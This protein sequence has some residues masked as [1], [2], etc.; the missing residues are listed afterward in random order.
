MVQGQAFGRTVAVTSM[1]ALALCGLLPVASASS[2]QPGESDGMRLTYDQPRVSAAGGRQ[3]P[4]ARAQRLEDRYI[5]TF[6]AGTDRKRVHAARKTAERAG[7]AAYYTYSEAVR[8][9]AAELT[10]SALAALR[11]DPD[12]ARIEPDYSISVASVQ[13]NPTNWGLDRIDQH[14]LPL[15]NSYSFEQTGTGITAY[16]I[17]TGVRSTHAELIGRVGKGTGFVDDGNGSEDCNGH[18][19]HVAAVLAGTNFGVAKKANVVSVRVLDCDG[20]GTI[21]GVVAGVDWVTKNHKGPSIANMSLGGVTSDTLDKAVKSSIASGVHYI[22]AAGNEGESACTFSPA[23]LPEAITVG[24]TGRTDQRAD[25]SNF[26]SC[27]DL[28]APGE[29]ILSADGTTDAGTTVLSGTSMA[30]PHV[31]GVAA[32]WLEL[33]P[34]ATADELR[35]AVVQIATPDVLGSIG[36]GSPNLLLFSALTKAPT[37]IGIGPAMALPRIVIGT[38]N[39]SAEGVVPVA[40]HLDQAAS[41]GPMPVRHELERSVDGGK[42][43]TSMPLPTPLA[44][45]VVFE[46]APG[47]LLLRAR[48]V[49]TQNLAGP[50][51]QAPARDIALLSESESTVY[52]PSTAWSDSAVEAATGKTVHVSQKTAATATFTFTGTQFAWFCG[53]NSSGRAAVY[54]DGEMVTIVDLAAL[55]AAK[56]RVAYLSEALAQ[57]KHTVVVKVLSAPIGKAA[58]GNG[59]DVDGWATAS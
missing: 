56:R 8:G 26:G 5:V 45:E 37:T 48:A 47:P 13:P 58:R 12:V 39:P 3:A 30:S 31:A 59:V 24:A 10:Y 21:S 42:T 4:A 36:R 11:L 40:V 20:S 9:F 51:A 34:L 33:H 15:D 19:T 50:W 55:G 25:F 27:V 41:G 49:D 53:G 14:A 52:Q 22:V 35:A 57:G 23:R 38:D 28:F 17:D 6:K 44:K 7:G 32:Q 18:G 2:P 1:V 43:W 29:D 46:M 16:V 54:I